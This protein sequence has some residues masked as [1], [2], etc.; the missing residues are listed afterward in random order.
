MFGRPRLLSES[1]ESFV[2]NMLV[3]RPAINYKK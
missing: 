3:C 1:K 2:V